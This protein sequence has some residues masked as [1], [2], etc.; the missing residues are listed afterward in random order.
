MKKIAKFSFQY[1]T[2]VYQKQILKDRHPEE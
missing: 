2:L 1:K